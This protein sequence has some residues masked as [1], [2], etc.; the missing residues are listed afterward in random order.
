MALY[1]KSKKMSY[2]IHNVQALIRFKV[3]IIAYQ[4]LL[5]FEMNEK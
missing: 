4:A 5:D 3:A 2:L 1:F